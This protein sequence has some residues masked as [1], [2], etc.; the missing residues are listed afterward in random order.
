MQEGGGCVVYSKKIKSNQVGE[1]EVKD[2]QIQAQTQKNNHT[3]Q[4]HQT[5]NN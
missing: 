5:C 2:L 3:C 4:A 1:K